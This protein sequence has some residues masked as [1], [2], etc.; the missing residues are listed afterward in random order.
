MEDRRVKVREIDEVTG[1]A[2]STV[3]ENIS[4]LNFR[5]VSARWLSKM[6]TQGHKSK[7]MASSLENLCHCQ[8]E[9]L[10]VE[11]IVMG[12][13]TWVYEFTPV[14]K[15]NFMTWKHPHSPTKKKIQN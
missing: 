8:D 12:D 15:R 6:L 2:K 9:E 10:F 7:R 1:I 4:D 11:N 5:K 3:H 13:E 14:S